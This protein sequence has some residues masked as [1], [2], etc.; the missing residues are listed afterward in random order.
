VIHKDPEFYPEDL[1]ELKFCQSYDGR[2]WT[3]YTLH[4]HKKTLGK[5]AAEDV[6]QW[7][8]SNR[9]PQHP[10]RI[11]DVLQRHLMAQGVMNS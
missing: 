6:D 2:N 5:V 4:D 9:L 1:Y 7:L 8:V 3:Y 10:D 11:T